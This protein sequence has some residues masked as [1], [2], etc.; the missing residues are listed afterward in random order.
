M[1]QMHKELLRRKH[2]LATQNVVWFMMIPNFNDRS[3]SDGSSYTEKWEN[4]K[5]DRRHTS[6]K[7]S[8][9]I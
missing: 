8:L 1:L 3:L 2:L 6:A 4:R 7:K 5:S 9:H